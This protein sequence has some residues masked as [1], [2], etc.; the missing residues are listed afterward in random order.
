MCAF[1]PSNLT[2]MLMF[3]FEYLP[4]LLNVCARF[5]VHGLHW[6]TEI[7]CLSGVK[8]VSEVPMHTEVD[9]C[10]HF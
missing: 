4:A 10:T 9:P 5:V 3:T 2:G 1:L 6:H 8:E 7:S